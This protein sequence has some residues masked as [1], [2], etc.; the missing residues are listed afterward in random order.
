MTDAVLSLLDG[1]AGLPLWALAAV[2]ALAVMAESSLLVGLVVPGDLI[3]L[4]AASSGGSVPRLALLV[5][6]V[7]AGSLAGEAVGY[8]LGRRWGGRVRTGRLGRALGEQRWAKAGAVLER[9]GSRAVFG[10]RYVAAVHAVLPVVAGTLRMPLRRFLGWSAM[11][12]LSWATIYVSVGAVAGASFR[13]AA[14]DLTVVTLVVIGA[15]AV[16]ASALALRSRRAAGRRTEA[17]G[18][19]EAAGPV[20]STPT[21]TATAPVAVTVRIVRSRYVPG[22]TWLVATEAPSAGTTGATRATGR[23]GA[24]PDPVLAL[25]PAGRDGGQAGPVR[26]RAGDGGGTGVTAAAAA[27]PPLP[28]RVAA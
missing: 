25:G 9:H 5:V 12:A 6:A 28:D 27:A 21:V 23:D 17:G 1:V 10:A 3:V 2:V 20:P 4:L 14:D 19:A 24:G 16:G 13:Q 26:H 22:T 7:A 11:G 8:L 18:R 15:L